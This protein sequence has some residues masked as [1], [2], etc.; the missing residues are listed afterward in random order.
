M[1]DSNFKKVLLKVLSFEVVVI[2]L[3]GL[4]QYRYNG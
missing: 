3:L 4:F 1:P 2:L